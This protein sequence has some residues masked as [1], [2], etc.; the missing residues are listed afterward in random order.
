MLSLNQTSGQAIRA[1]ACLA[2]CGEDW[3]LAKEVAECCTV[4][5]PYL[6]K[7]LLDLRR[8]GLVE[9]KR[10]YQGGFRL[11]RPPE[12]ISLFEVIEAV[13]PSA[14]ESRCFYGTSSCSKESPCS[15]HDFWSDLRTGV[16][17]FLRETS[18]A[19]TAAADWPQQLT[20]IGSTPPASPRSSGSGTATGSAYRTSSPAG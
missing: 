15:I 10:G 7:V 8:A 14:H 16:E 9:A 12:E 4:P 19:T 11:A 18:V 1:L 5:L 3:H 20:L 2:R 13:E 17:T 6:Q